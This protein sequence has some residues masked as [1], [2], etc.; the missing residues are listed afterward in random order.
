MES[1]TNDPERSLRRSGDELEERIERIEQHLADAKHG[2]RDRKE[3][4]GRPV[5]DVAGDWEATEDDAGGE[6]PEGAAEG[7]HHGPEADDAGDAPA[8]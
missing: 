2:L 6:D 7:E 5:E 1:G 3:D 8:G 4:A